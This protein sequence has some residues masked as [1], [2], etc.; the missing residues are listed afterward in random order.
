MQKHLSI[1]AAAAL[2]VGGMGLTAA[3]AQ[4]TADQNTAAG[5]T[6]PSD[7]L[8]RAGDNAQTAADKAAAGQGLKGTAQA[9]DA[10]GIR[11]VLASATEAAFTPGGFDDL[12]ERLVDADRN[13]IGKAMPSDDDLKS[14]NDAIKSFRDA[15]KAKYGKDFDIDNEE[16]VFNETFQ[17]Q[18]SEIGNN[19][20]TAGDRQSS[21]AS[22][23]SGKSSEDKTGDRAVLGN[24]DLQT[25]PSARGP[26]GGIDMDK[27]ASEDLANRRSGK[28]I[29]GSS[30]ASTNSESTKIAGAGGTVDDKTS[31]NPSGNQSTPSASS[32]GSDSA[33]SGSVSTPAGNAS[34]SVSADTSGARNA[35]DRAGDA[36]ANAAQRTGDAV[37]NAADRTGDAASNAADRAQ[38]AT[39][40]DL[41][42]SGTAD[43]NTNDPGRNIATVQVPESH[44]LPALSVKMIH[45][46]PDA[47]RIDVPDSVDGAKLQANLTNVVG[48]CMAM[49]D[50]WPA[51]VNEAY[52]AVGHK[53]LAAVHDKPIS[54]GGSAGAGAAQ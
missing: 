18:Q 29:S 38:Q 25:G 6:T 15:W 34:G 53:V 33:A 3:W 21:D 10:E 11:D 9:P 32:S 13:R 40:V 8:Q 44:G 49:K 43:A 5:Q 47:W 51:D 26:R 28:N 23:Q 27:A 45:E 14:H 22:G 20:R 4:Q 16:L 24:A 31:Q 37:K 2:T 19:A 39:G 42:G 54:A 7:S 30:N 52:R 50:Q 17:I 35:A 1:V 36:T 46:F 41:P 12:V 48:A